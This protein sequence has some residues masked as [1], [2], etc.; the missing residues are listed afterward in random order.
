MSTPPP[1]GSLPG[2]SPGN[3]PA[4]SAET[5]PKPDA[6]GEENRAAKAATPVGK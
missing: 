6:T 5:A 4:P 3:A 2:T 1:Q